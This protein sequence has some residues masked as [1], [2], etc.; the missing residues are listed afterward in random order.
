VVKF[1]WSLNPGRPGRPTSASDRSSV[2]EQV[3]LAGPDPSGERLPLIGA[4]DQLRAVRVL[5][6]TDGD[7]TRQVVG[8]LDAVPAVAAA[9]G[10]LAPGCDVQARPDDSLYSREILDAPAQ[11]DH[12]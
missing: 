4:E 9:V 12:K 11:D 8:H 1:G 10:A 3:E 2:S 5:G 7:D 6:V